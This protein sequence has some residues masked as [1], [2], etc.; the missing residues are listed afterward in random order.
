M[1]NETGPPWQRGLKVGESID[2][3]KGLLIM[4]LVAVRSRFREFAL[5]CTSL[6]MKLR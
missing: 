3:V 5:Y 4:G 1:G 6:V 2:C